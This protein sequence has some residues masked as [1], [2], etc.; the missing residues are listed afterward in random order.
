MVRSPH[1]HLYEARLPK[2]ALKQALETGWREREEDGEKCLSVALYARGR[3]VERI[4][5]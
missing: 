2:K 1:D 3:A 4:G 5:N